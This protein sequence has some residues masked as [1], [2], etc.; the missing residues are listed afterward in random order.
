MDQF[1]VDVRSPGAHDAEVY[2]QLRLAMASRSDV[3]DLVMMNCITV[4]EF[5]ETGI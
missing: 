3:P 4:P 1:D 2:Q 5:T